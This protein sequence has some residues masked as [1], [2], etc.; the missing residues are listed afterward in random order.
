MPNKNEWDTCINDC[1]KGADK[2]EIE[3]VSKLA[4]AV[5]KEKKLRGT[6]L[7]EILSA[8]NE[9]DMRVIARLAAAVVGYKKERRKSGQGY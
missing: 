7:S 2:K 8:A 3:L 1:L 6:E 5:V 9:K 4:A